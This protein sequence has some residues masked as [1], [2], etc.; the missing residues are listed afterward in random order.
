MLFEHDEN[1]IF[2]CVALSGLF[3]STP[4]EK[5]GREK[6]RVICKY[7]IFSDLGTVNKMNLLISHSFL[8]S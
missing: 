4:A 7:F 1:E 5:L 6:G 8:L 3:Y 2:A